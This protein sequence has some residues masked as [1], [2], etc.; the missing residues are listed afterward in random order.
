MLLTSEELSKF[1]NILE[2]LLTVMMCETDGW[3]TDHD[4]VEKSP[5]EKCREFILSLIRSNVH[6]N[7]F[8]NENYYTEPTETGMLSDLYLC[9]QEES[10]QE[11]NVDTSEI[12]KFLNNIKETSYQNSKIKGTF[13]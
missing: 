3:V 4:Q 8:D 9:D 10:D 6:D 13:I 2:S 12:E 1:K 7:S 11:S 5:S